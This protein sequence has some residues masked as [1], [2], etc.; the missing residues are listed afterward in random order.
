MAKDKKKILFLINKLKRGGAERMFVNQLNELHKRGW[1]VHLSLVYGSQGKDNFLDELEFIGDKI[2]IFGFKNLADLSAWKR[3]FRYIKKQRPDIIYSTLGDANH[4]SRI[5]RLFEPSLKVVIRESTV[6]DSKTLPG[7][8]IDWFLNFFADT[9]VAVSQEVKRSL[10]QFESTHQKKIYVI[11]NGVRLPEPGELGRVKDRSDSQTRILSVGSLK[12]NKN[13]LLLLDAFDYLQ[14]EK[15]KVRLDIVGGGTEKGNLEKFIHERGLG[16][17]VVLV[18]EVNSDE[19]RKRY[20]QADLFVFPS[21]KE[22]CPNAVLE[23]MAYGLPIIL[24]DM[25]VAH[26]LVQDGR[27]GLIVPFDAAALADKLGELIRDSVKREEMGKQA[28][29]YAE[30]NFALESNI[31]QLEELFSHLLQRK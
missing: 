30:D 26:E 8:Y 2:E 15:V 5:A 6:A 21:Q 28:R 1:D 23:A 14:K 18:G 25:G 16:R 24:T 22:G 3:F 11:Y 13:H 27:N 7:K 19:L 4:I 20:R 31:R 10:L 29:Q 12:A 17:S 9:I